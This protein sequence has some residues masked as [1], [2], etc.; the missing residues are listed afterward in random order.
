MYTGAKVNEALLLYMI[1]MF[2]YSLVYFV[3]YEISALVKKRA[4]KADREE[5]EA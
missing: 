5:A 2:V 4:D 1:S 3:R